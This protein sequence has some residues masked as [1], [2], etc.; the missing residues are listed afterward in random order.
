MVKGRTLAESKQSQDG[1][2]ARLIALL[3]FQVESSAGC[4][5]SYAPPDGSSGRSEKGRHKEGEAL[6]SPLSALVSLC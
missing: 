2:E 5:K 4:K 6:A 1:T 3:P